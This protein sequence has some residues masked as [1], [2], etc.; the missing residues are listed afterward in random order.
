M[1]SLALYQSGKV[2]E[3]LELSES[4]FSIID[5]SGPKPLWREMA[6]EAIE[7]SVRNQVQQGRSS[8]A[9]E[10]LEKAQNILASSDIKN[11]GSLARC[12]TLSAWVYRQKKEHQTALELAERALGMLLARHGELHPYARAASE[13]LQE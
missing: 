5:E 3:A 4:V 12:L 2:A 1:L 9:I 11:Y 8:A 7:T 6:Y 13:L 10:L